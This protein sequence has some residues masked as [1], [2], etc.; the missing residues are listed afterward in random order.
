MESHYNSGCWKS[1]CLKPACQ[2]IDF[3]PTAWRTADYPYA[4]E[5]LHM[6]LSRVHIAIALT[7]I[8]ALLLA[9]CEEA[10]TPTAPPEPTAS[11]TPASS[12]QTPIGTA[13]PSPTPTEDSIV[14]EPYLPPPLACGP[15]TFANPWSIVPRHFVFWTPDS[16][17]L[18][19]S[20][21]KGTI[22]IVDADGSNLNKVLDANPEPFA[23]GSTELLYG[24]HG[25]LSPDGTQIV[26]TSCQFPTDYIYEY[27]ETEVRSNAVLYERGKYN[28]EVATSGLDGSNQQRLT[29]N[30]HIDTLPVWSP[31]GGRLAFISDEAGGRFGG[32]VLDQKLHVMMADGSNV[33]PIPLPFDVYGLVPPVWSPDGDRLAVVLNEPID[34]WYVQLALYTTQSDGSESAKLADLGR[35][36]DFS[37]I[38][39]PVAAPSWSPDSERVAFA[40]F[41]REE[42]SVVYSASFDGTDLRRLWSSGT[43]EEA[44]AATQVSWSP[45]GSE[46]LFVADDVHVVGVDGDGLR[47]LISGVGES[48]KAAWSPD[49]SMIAVYDPGRSSSI[50]VVP[51]EWG[52]TRYDNIMLATLSRDGTD[53]RVL[54]EYDPDLEPRLVQP[55]RPEAT[56]EPAPGSPTPVPADPAATPPGTR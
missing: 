7:A 29:S 13:I 53:L 14:N 34:R 54:V 55:T 6:R 17:Q 35:L 45:D 50:P 18:V 16:S 28:Y 43:G 38:R 41:D 26:Y 22:W 24:F 19:F 10:P 37:F 30:K 9:S 36:G 8:V 56:A 20:G 1:F 3:G 15:A 31:D 46:I 21:D 4:P 52:N 47:T 32:Y 42:G 23:V 33:Q 11:P 44:I 39:K 12:A 48:T 40:T 27:V 51:L 49:G 2:G 25:D 5:G